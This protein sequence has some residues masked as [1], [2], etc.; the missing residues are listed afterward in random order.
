MPPSGYLHHCHCSPNPAAK[1]YPISE[2][3]R[4]NTLFGDIPAVD[5]DGTA[6]Q[7]GVGQSSKFTTI[8]ALKGLTKEDMFLTLQD[9]IRNHGAP[10]HI[11]ANNASTYCGS[12]F[13]KYL[14][15]LWIGLWQSELYKQK[16]NYT[17]N[18]W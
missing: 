2:I 17:E 15:D 3:D 9:R 8:H 4:T 16:Q 14:C 13:S 5:N 12:K 6:A 18:R 10:G 1:F 7:L 11:A